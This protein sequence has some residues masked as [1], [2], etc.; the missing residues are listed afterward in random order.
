MAIADSRYRFVTIEVGA[1]GSESDGGVW[2]HSVFGKKLDGEREEI[3][4][5]EEFASL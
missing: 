4:I 2:E 5:S 1:C 3:V